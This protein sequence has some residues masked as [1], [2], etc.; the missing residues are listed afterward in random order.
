[1]AGIKPKVEVL[2]GDALKLIG[3][4]E[5]EFDMVFLDANKREYL[6]YL[7]LVEDKLHKGSVVVVDNA[8]SFAD[9]MKD[10]LDYVR[11]SGKY[12]SRFIPVGDGDGGGR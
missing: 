9:L 4:L 7:K 8:G 1:M 2:V 10:Y 11:K 3:E 6:E 5:G 12:D